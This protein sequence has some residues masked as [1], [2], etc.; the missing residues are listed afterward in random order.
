MCFMDQLANQNDPKRW[1]LHYFSVYLFN[2]NVILD[3]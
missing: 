2:T 3:S 1:F